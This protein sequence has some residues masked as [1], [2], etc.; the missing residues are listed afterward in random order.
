MH[1]PMTAIA[2]QAAATIDEPS[3]QR[4][5]EAMAPTPPDKREEDLAILLDL[6]EAQRQLLDDA[7]EAGTPRGPAPRRDGPPVPPPIGDAALRGSLD[8]EQ[9]HKL[10][11]VERL[12]RQPQPPA[13]FDRNQPPP[14]P[15]PSPDF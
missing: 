7:R 13:G 4:R 1:W 14:P 3:A 9:R 2:T 15:P 12:L 11:V 8:A 6:T 5:A 10:A